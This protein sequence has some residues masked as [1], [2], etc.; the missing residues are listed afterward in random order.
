VFVYHLSPYQ[1]GVVV[2]GGGEVM[3]HGITAI[4]DAQPNWVVL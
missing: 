1:F 2:K 3:I 4:L